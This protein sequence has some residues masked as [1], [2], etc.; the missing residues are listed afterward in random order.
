M[1]TEPRTARSGDVCVLLEPAED[2]AAAVRKLQMSLQSVFGGRPHERVHLT[3]QRF[4]VGQE[5][6]NHDLVQHLRSNLA[7]IQP[8]AVTAGSLVQVESRFWQSRLL[9]WRILVT[10][11]VRRF[12]RLVED[13]LVATGVAPHFPHSSGWVPTHVTALEAIPSVDLDRH[14]SRQHFPQHLFTG[15]QVVLSKIIGP[16]QF[17]IL[18]TIQLDNRHA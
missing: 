18:E 12:G 17:D 7:A 1:P 3:C 13:G 5:R 14:L 9:R 8:F 4:E 16:R 15:R 11:D 10:T 6:L 2:G